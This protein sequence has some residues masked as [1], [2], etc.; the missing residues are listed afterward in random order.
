MELVCRGLAPAWHG[1]V[2]PAGC[3]PLPRVTGV[4][5]PAWALPHWAAFLEFPYLQEC[6]LL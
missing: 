6:E 1:P 2:M 4:S 3:S 5:L